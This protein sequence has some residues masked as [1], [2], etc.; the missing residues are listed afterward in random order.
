MILY[1]F[2]HLIFLQPRSSYNT[3]N[4]DFSCLWRN[5]RVKTGAGSRQQVSRNILWFYIRIFFQKKCHICFHSFYKFRIRRRIVI[6]AGTNA[7]KF[8]SVLISLGSIRIFYVYIVMVS[9]RSAPQIIIFCKFLSYI[10]CCHCFTVYLYQTAFSLMWEK[11]R[12][13]A[14]K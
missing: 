3:R 1:D 14:G 13:K 8:R 9:R 6:R 12:R 10:L 2:T 11:N 5:M 7:G 4:L